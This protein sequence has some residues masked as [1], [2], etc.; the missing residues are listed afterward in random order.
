[1]TALNDTERAAQN[2]SVARPDRPAPERAERPS[3]PS[4]GTATPRTSRYYPAWLPSRRFIAA[5][6][7]IG[8]MQLLATTDSTVAIL[9]LPKIQNELSLLDAGRIWV[10]IAYVLSVGGRMPLVGRLGGV[11][12]GKPTVSPGVA[13]FAIS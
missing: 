13:L 12:G 3:E 1:M 9:A 6:I 10:M 8:G 4:P 7:A 5:V 2:W 11:I